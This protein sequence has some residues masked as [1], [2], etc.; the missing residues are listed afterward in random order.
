MPP[1]F[2]FAARGGDVL[3][4]L[5]FALVALVISSLAKKKSEADKAADERRAQ[6]AAVV[7]SSEDAIFNK[8]LDGT[9]L[10][11]NR[12]AQEMYG[13]NPEE[14]IGRN[15]AV[16]APPEKAGEIAGVLQRLRRG[17]RIAPFETERVT[18]D[19]RRIDVSLSISPVFDNEGETCHCRGVRG[20]HRSRNE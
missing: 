20:N 1:R 7:E 15:I 5:F 11:W 2:S 18:K 8:T 12:A 14:M 10:T 17:E 4:L 19:G 3:R 16:L 9:V 6:L 13:Y